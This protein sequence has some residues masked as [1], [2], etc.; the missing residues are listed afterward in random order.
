MGMGIPRIVLAGASLGN[1]AFKFAELPLTG[2]PGMGDFDT[3]DVS[4]VN[5]GMRS[6]EVFPF[7]SG[8]PNPV[9]VVG[10]GDVVVEESGCLVREG[11]RDRAP[12]VDIPGNEWRSG[13]IWE[14]VCDPPPK[15][16]GWI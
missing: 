15:I 3:G 6:C 7:P 8:E 12:G 9:W 2:V 5:R 11:R 10:L 16:A 1:I 14:T 13:S 4:K